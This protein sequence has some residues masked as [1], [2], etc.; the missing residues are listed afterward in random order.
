MALVP[1]AIDS[2]VPFVSD[3]DGG[4]SLLMLPLGTGTVLE[5]L[6]GELAGDMVSVGQVLVMPTFTPTPAYQEALRRSTSIPLQIV[7]PELLAVRLSGYEANAHLLVVEPARW[8]GSGYDPTMI[9]RRLREY[10]GAT[11]AVCVD[12]NA[13]TTR[14]LVQLD[15]DGYVRR[16]QR[17]YNLM[18]WPETAGTSIAWSLVPAHAAGEVRFR[19]LRELRIALSA[20]GVLSRDVPAVASMVDLREER[21]FL[22]LHERMLAELENA[23]SVGGFRT[24][25]PEILVAEDA[26]VA[27]SARL[28]GPVVV[29]SGAEV[30]ADSLIIGPTAIGPGCRVG[31]SATIAQSVLIARTTVDESTT[32][33]HRVASGHCATSLTSEGLDMEVVSEVSTSNGM[34]RNN[35]LYGEDQIRSP[36]LSSMRGRWAHL[37]IKR[38]VDLISSAAA[39]IVLSPVLVLVAVLVKLDS[40]GPVFFVHRRER[41]GGKEF[42]CY[43]FRTMVMGADAKQRE[44]AATNEVD[45]PQF[46]ITNDP[47][48]TLLGRWLRGTNIDELPQLI[49]VFLGHMSLVGPRPS[50]FRENQICVPWRLARLSVRPGITGLWQICRAEDRSRG[51]FHEWIYYDIQY[52][53]HFSIWLDIKIL[54]AT[55]VTLGGRSSVPLSW[56]ISSTRTPIENENQHLAPV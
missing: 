49:N 33:R 13:E 25:E 42:P 56:L 29:H 30:E 18:H 48:V 34:Q 20:R 53:R 24:L 28:V 23:G 8:P 7:S 15:A 22:A 10:R 4:S 16:V 9:A 5:H 46:K 6:V 40:P 11:H 21:G 37:V 43:K 27:P 26:K 45:G 17:F 12:A 2:K 14:E 41:K 55:L 54:L 19:S 39:L 35:G 31:R 44:L 1:L 52:V 36:A 32:I 38:A 51:D 47:R 50:P 3:E